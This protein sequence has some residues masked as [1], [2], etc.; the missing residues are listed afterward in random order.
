MLLQVSAPVHILLTSLVTTSAFRSN[1]LAF[2]KSEAQ[3]PGMHHG[4]FFKEGQSAFRLDMLAS[5]AFPVDTMV[6]NVTS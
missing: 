1:A 6:Q 2:W 5:P 3:H 4:F